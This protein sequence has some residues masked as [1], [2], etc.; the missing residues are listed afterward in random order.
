M[1][2]KL[3]VY[4]G[5]KIMYGD[6]E[7]LS[8]PSS[9]KAGGGELEGRK[10]VDWWIVATGVDPRIP[11]IPGLDHPNVLSYLDVIRRDANIGD[12]VS[13]IGRGV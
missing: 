11:P 13:I 1:G 9:S 4:L 8:P 7:H 12:R 3:M 2:G 6:M 5:T 10:G